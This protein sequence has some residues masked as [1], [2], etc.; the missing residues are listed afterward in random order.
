VGKIYLHQPAT[1]F[2]CKSAHTHC[3][4]YLRLNSDNFMRNLA[5]SL[6]KAMAD[7]FCTISSRFAAAYYPVA[8]NKK[9]FDRSVVYCMD[10]LT[11]SCQP[12]F[13]KEILDDYYQKFYWEN[14]NAI[15]G[16]HL[17]L[18]DRPNDRQ[19]GLTDERIAWIDQFSPRIE[20]VID[21]GAGDCAAGFTYAKRV[22]A[23]GV[24]VVDPSV[25]ASALAVQYGLGYAR[26]V[27]QAPVVDLIYGAHVLEHVPDLLKS[28]GELLRQVR[29]GGHIFLE[30]P[31]IGDLAVFKEMCHTPHTFMLSAQ[32]FK[33]LTSIFP[34]KIIGLDCCGPTWQKNRKQIRSAEKADL[35][36]LLQKTGEMHNM[37]CAK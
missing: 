8:V 25:R 34:I 24:D 27:G 37:E 6:P 11:G 13:E 15:D 3:F 32:S 21:F 9:Y 5:Y 2:L 33:F 1:C 31:N 14:R 20:S 19:L 29:L 22:G 7:S 18:G 26:N 12:R 35:R 23:R 28:I 4:D 30:T 36:V 17:S 16:A 10:C